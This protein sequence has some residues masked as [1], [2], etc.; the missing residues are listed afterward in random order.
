VRADA[1]RAKVGGR[2]AHLQRLQHTKGIKT[3]RLYVCFY[4]CCVGRTSII[5]SCMAVLPATPSP[6]NSTP[7]HTATQ[8]HTQDT[9]KP[10]APLI[11]RFPGGCRPLLGL[12]R[13]VCLCLGGVARE[14]DRHSQPPD[15]VR[16]M[17]VTRI[18]GTR[19]GTVRPELDTH[20]QRERE[21]GSTQGRPLVRGGSRGTDRGPCLTHRGKR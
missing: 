18:Q 15:E 12:C 1:R 8:P 14:V 7:T 5:R 16:A 11:G 10:S 19:R 13:T 3:R 4:V 9:A 17:G 2:I 6:S 21:G 20:T